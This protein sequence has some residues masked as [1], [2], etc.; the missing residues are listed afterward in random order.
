MP[1]PPGLP[2]PQRRLG[3]QQL[4]A[5]LRL[6]HMAAGQNPLCTPG[7]REAS[8]R[9]NHIVLGGGCHKCH[10]SHK[11]QA[12]PAP[13]GSQ[14]HLDRWNY[15]CCSSLQCLRGQLHPSSRPVPHRDPPPPSPLS[16]IGPPRQLS[17][18]CSPG[19]SMQQMARPQP[20]IQ[21]FFSASE[22]VLSDGHQ[23]GAPPCRLRQSVVVPDH[24]RVPTVP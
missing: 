14:C 23:L 10:R 19:R 5:D 6:S 11:V 18:Q 24:L 4:L 21:D 3:R 13:T 17:A 1:R 8:N 15:A 7:H 16:Q 20:L 12:P 2:G 9:A 22:H